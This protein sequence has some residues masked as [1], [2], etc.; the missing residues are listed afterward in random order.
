MDNR[1]GQIIVPQHV[2]GP[3]QPEPDTPRLPD[4]APPQPVPA[5]APG[6]ETAQSQLAPPQ[7]QPAVP[8]VP[9]AEPIQEAGWQF[10]QTTPSAPQSRQPLPNAEGLTWTA[11]E[12]TAHEKNAGWHGLLA[13]VG[14]LAAVADYL[15]FKDV[16]SSVAIVLA[17]GSL[18]ALSSRKPRAQQY[19]VT[20][21][22]IQIGAKSY[23]FQD[24]KNFSIAEERGVS[25]IIFMPL[26]RFM[27]AL[28][29][30]V[31]PDMED[32]VIDFLSG[33]LPFEQ[34]RPDAVDTLLRRIHF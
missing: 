28:T 25:S 12:S 21:Q 16:V 5:P 10:H 7:L 9:V 14:L 34:H 26:K 17:V 8:P 30:Y 13:F 3:Q 31:T 27:P 22:G 19:A 33:I 4:D 29:V 11:S 6:P 32:Q 18:A 1:P 15:L 20:F 24:F 2:E 23:F